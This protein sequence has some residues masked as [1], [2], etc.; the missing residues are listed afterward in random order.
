MDPSDVGQPRTDYGEP[1]FCNQCGASVTAAER[2][3]EV[4][5]AC[6]CGHVQSRR[7]TVGVAV[8]VLQGDELLVVRR[9]FGAKAGLWC[10]PCGHVGWD[11][12]VRAAAV[13]ELAEETGLVVELDRVLDVHSNLWRPE[14]QTVGIWFMGRRVAGGLRAGDDAA[15]A[16]FVPLNRIGIDVDLAFDTDQLVVDQLRRSGA[17]GADVGSSHEPHRDRGQA[18]P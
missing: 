1:R 12:D 10:I 13:R 18:Q 14:R 17:A 9:A 16:R 5:W 11:E 15:E 4:A 7:P 2:H 8:V 3:G 6:A